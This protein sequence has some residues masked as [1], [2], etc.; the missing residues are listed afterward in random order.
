LPEPA[1]PRAPVLCTC[2]RLTG[3]DIRRIIDDLRCATVEDVAEATGAC[4]GCQ[5]CRP[6]IEGLLAEAAARRGG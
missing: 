3:A 1:G 4:R 5:T 2:F 6:D